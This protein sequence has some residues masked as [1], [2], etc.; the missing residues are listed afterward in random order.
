[1]LD[2]NG[3][4]IEEF[5]VLKIFHFTGARRKKHY[6]YKVAIMH[7]GKLYGSHIDS[8]P[9]KPNFPLWCG[10]YSDI[11]EIVQ[12]RNYDKLDKRKKKY[13]KTTPTR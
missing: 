5:D 7:N 6:M 10:D 11:T 9:L 1:M 12:S 4:E 13:A 2:K 8:N 3:V